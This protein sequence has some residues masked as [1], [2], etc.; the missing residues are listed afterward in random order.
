MIHQIY[1]YISH[2]GLKIFSQLWK[3]AGSPKKVICMVHGIGE[4]SGRYN[5]WAEK[6][7]DE[8]IA[9]FAFDL[10]GHGNSEGKRGDA[11]NYDL[12]MLDIDQA[13]SETKKQFPNISIILYGHSLGGNF[14]INYLLRKNPEITASIVSSPWLELAFKVPA[15]KMILGKLV[16]K[17][18][19][20]LIQSNGLHIEDL[21]RTVAVFDL[22][23]NDPLV[24]NK[25]SLRLYFA[26]DNSGIWALENSEKLNISLLLM[27][28]DKDRI[29]S[30]KAS[31]KFAET[32]K[33]KT[34]FKLWS[35]YYHELHNEPENKEVA[36]Y[37]L[38]WIKNL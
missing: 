12:F 31:I 10:R 2:D 26:A 28:G 30:Y 37:I 32:S 3:P 38:T 19:P 15:F 4:H 33:Q 22:L 13:L 5:I 24:H 35:N 17:I 14:V 9:F 16:Y 18:F 21:T 25:I 27:H 1:T 6:F 29:T 11:A 36:D 20:G 34:T 23:R 8:G 7:V